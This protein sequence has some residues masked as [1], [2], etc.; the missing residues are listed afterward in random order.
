MPRTTRRAFVLDTSVI[1][2]DSDC[3]HHFGEHD[4]VVP[5]SVVE[6]LEGRKRGREALNH[7]ARVFLRALD[8]LSVGR[9]AEGGARIGPGLGL[10]SVRLEAPCHP[11]L[12]ATFRIDNGRHR[13]LN[14][15]YLIAKETPR[16]EVALVSKDAGLRVK[17]RAAGL[18]AED[19][20][21]D[22]VADLAAVQASPRL[23]TDVGGDRLESLFTAPYLVAPKTLGLTEPPGANEFL[24]MRDGSRSALAI[25]DAAAAVIRLIDPS[26]A[27]GITP[28]N[29]E[30][31]FALHALMSDSIQLVAITGKA[32]TGK[33][34]LALAAAL[35]CRRSFDQI[36]VV[37]PMVPPGHQVE[38][39]LAMDHEPKLPPHLR[40]L[41]DNLG[42]IRAQFGVTDN[43]RRRIEA[44]LDEGKLIIEPLAYS[45]DRNLGRTYL[46]VDGAQNL[47]PHEI[48][49]LV[50]RAA[51]GTKVV[52]TGDTRQVD[53]PY[54]DSRSNGLSY[55]I[56]KMKGQP[57]CAHVNLVRGERS[58]LA[59]LAAAML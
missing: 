31:T 33:T 59:D 5:M 22:R 41:H 39:T 56:E 53:H 25:Y 1:L 54:L 47:T 6:D 34:L 38:A 15:A 32:G 26:P 44:F 58:A 40:P 17:A 8:G 27:Y 19:Y 37:R 13:V 18:T 50:T 24:V 3:L 48:K 46:V 7:H 45:H 55:L 23:L 28:R 29:A 43:K 16:R 51:E 42:V 4:L 14:V 2:H 49:A 9:L 10:L 12:K 20:D 11:D 36:L 52:L 30:Q 35:E 57:L 21:T